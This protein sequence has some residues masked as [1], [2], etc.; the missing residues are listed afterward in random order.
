MSGCDCWRKRES[1]RDSDGGRLRQWQLRTQRAVAEQCSSG[2]WGI[3][4]R[5]EEGL[6]IVEGRTVSANLA[7]M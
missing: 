5:E 6:T 3:G 7:T 4:F 2:C 1:M